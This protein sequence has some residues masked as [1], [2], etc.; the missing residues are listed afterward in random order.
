MLALQQGAGNGCCCINIHMLQI[1][2]F[3]FLN[4]CCQY[5]TEALAKILNHLNGLAIRWLF[6]A[7]QPALA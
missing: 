2:L 6:A 4:H 7:S 3:L 5:Q 1:L